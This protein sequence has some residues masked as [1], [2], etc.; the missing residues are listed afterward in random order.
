MLLWAIIHESVSSFFIPVEGSVLTMIRNLQFIFVFAVA[1]LLPSS[2]QRSRPPKARS[3]PLLLG[4]TRRS[5]GC[6]RQL[7][8]MHRWLRCM[9]SVLPARRPADKQ[10]SCTLVL[11]RAQFEALVS[12]LNVSNQNYPP[13]AL[14]GFATNY[15]N[16]LAL[17]RAGETVGVEKDPRFK[18]LMTIASAR[19]FAESYRRYLQ[20]KYSNPSDEEI[21]AY[22]RQNM[23][24]FEQVK[25]DRI[26]IPKVDPT[27]PQDRR[28][29]FET[30]AKKLPVISGNARREVK[31]LRRSRWRYIKLWV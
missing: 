12:S 16:I 19:A 10:D 31:T 29:E 28:P 4:E 21:A 24:K 2:N 15:A 30:K 27:R 17:A 9:A 6:W 20:E 7:R 3:H 5:P 1:P 8:Q 23:D 26:H 22:Y 14:R 25:I 13:P 11:T 18:D